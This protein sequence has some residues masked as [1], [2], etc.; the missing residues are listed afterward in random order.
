MGP[1]LRGTEWGLSSTSWWFGVFSLAHL[2]S[3]RASAH[4]ASVPD[5][6]PPHPEARR[7][8]EDSGASPLT[9]SLICISFS[10]YYRAAGR[11]SV[12][13]AAV[14]KVQAAAIASD[15]LKTPMAACRITSQPV[16]PP[17]QPGTGGGGGDQG[18][19][20]RSS[21]Q[22][23]KEGRPPRPSRPQGSQAQLSARQRPESIACFPTPAREDGRKRLRLCLAFCVIYFIGGF[24][25]ARV[26][27]MREDPS[28]QP[29]RLV[30]VHLLN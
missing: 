22:K 29:F 13:T 6:S 3:S 19:K 12:L 26:G 30:R 4:I 8:G 15:W 14:S 1:P 20:G 25:A 23:S 18:A 5:R 17:P 21:K 16:S 9:K 28:K 10:S 11:E 7:V 2:S 27:R 24:W